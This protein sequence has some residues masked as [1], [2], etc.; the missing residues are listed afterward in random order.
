VISCTTSTAAASRLRTLTTPVSPFGLP[1]LLP[2]PVLPQQGMRVPVAS[3]VRMTLADHNS[4][5]ASARYGAAKQ[6]AP[7][8][9]VPR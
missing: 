6:A 9:G 3:V 7:P 2:T 8:R 1:T 5:N 4:I